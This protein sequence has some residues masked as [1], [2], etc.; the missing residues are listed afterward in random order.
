MKSWASFFGTKWILWVDEAGRGAWAW[1]VVAG[2][3]IVHDNTNYEYR[4]LLKDLRDSKTLSASRRE[5]LYQRITTLKHAGILSVVTSKKSSGIIDMKWIRETNRL[6]MLSC[7]RKLQSKSK[8]AI[9]HICIDGRD[10]YLFRMYSVPKYFIKWDAYIPEIMIAAIAAK[11]TRDRHM[12]RLAKKYPQYGF[13]MHKGYGTQ[14]HHEALA[15]LWPLSWVHR[16]SYEPIKNLSWKP[17]R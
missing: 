11:V 5:N 12:C 3:C 15:K 13:E 4:E 1:P 8:G 2:A 6:A 14:A 7:I 16:M 17:R 9:K 10:K